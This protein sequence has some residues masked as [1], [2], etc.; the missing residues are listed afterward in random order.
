MYME[1]NNLDILDIRVN[2]KYSFIQDN[3]F[4][5]QKDETRLCYLFKMSTHRRG[6]GVD[7]VRRMSTDKCDLH[8]C[9]VVFDHVKRIEGWT[10]L[11]AYV[12]DPHYRGVMT[13]TTCDMKAKDKLPQGL[14]W[15]LINNKT[16]LKY[17]IETVDFR[18]FMADGVQT[19]WN[20]VREVYSEGKPNPL[21]EQTCCFH[22]EENLKRHSIDLVA[23]EFREESKKRCRSGRTPRHLRRRI[24]DMWIL[25]SGTRPRVQQ[26][27]EWLLRS[28]RSIWRG[29]CSWLATGVNGCKMTCPLRM[30]R[31]APTQIWLNPFIAFGGIQQAMD[32]RK[33]QTL[34]QQPSMTL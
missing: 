7:I 23:I 10:T 32:G 1:E 33:K 12:Y 9:W 21:K 30:Q 19:N 25:L 4:H 20:A 24:I 17:G 2:T 11:A 18:G 13:I 15:K 26:N 14:F 6:S 28:W 8:R 3:C 16:C 5:G 34:F 29:G 22:W 31:D 27:H